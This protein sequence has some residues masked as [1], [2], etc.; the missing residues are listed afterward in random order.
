MFSFFFDPCVVIW[1]IT[2][3]CRV[4]KVFELLFF[5]AW[6]SFKRHHLNLLSI[7]NF[8]VYRSLHANFLAFRF[9]TD[10]SGILSAQPQPIGLHCHWLQ[11]VYQCRRSSMPLYATSMPFCQSRKIKWPF[12]GL[13]RFLG[14]RGGYLL[15]HFLKRERKK[16]KKIEKKIEKGKNKKE[17]RRKKKKKQRRR[18][19]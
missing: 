16:R 1:A 12:A 18:M 3:P 7:S 8:S 19:F 5:I 15:P 6:L 13:N 10:R 11:A 14:W 9:R 4:R 17:R 2:L